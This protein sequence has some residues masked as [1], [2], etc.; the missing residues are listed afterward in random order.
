MGFRK[1]RYSFTRNREGYREIFQFQGDKWNTASEEP[2][3]CFLNVGVVFTDIGEA[4]SWEYIPKTH[5]A[6]RPSLLS[7]E[8]PS[9][10]AYGATVNGELQAGE[11]ARVIERTSEIVGS[12]IDEL[13]QECLDKEARWQERMDA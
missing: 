6:R 9:Y 8:L 13:R 11:I 1:E 12:M 2:S 7:D 4:Q 5:W 3:H 10:F